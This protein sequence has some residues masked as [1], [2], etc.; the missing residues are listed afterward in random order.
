MEMNKDDEKKLCDWRDALINSKTPEPNTWYTH[1]IHTN[2]QANT[3]GDIRNKTRN[4]LIKGSTNDVGR[5]TISINT[6]TK[7]KHRFVMECLYEV[8]IPSGYDIDHVDQNAGNNKFAN[9]R[10]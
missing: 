6:H 10:Y 3:N 9:L 4:T 2:Y 8:E 7:Q 1:P 5:T